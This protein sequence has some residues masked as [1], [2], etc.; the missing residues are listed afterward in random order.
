[1][2]GIS[3]IFLQESDLLPGLEFVRIMLPSLGLF[4]QQINPF[5]T[6]HFKCEKPQTYFDQISSCPWASFRSICMGMAKNGSHQIKGIFL[7]IKIFSPLCIS[8]NL[9]F[10]FANLFRSFPLCIPFTASFVALLIA[11]HLGCEP[12]Q[13]LT[14]LIC[15]EWQ[16]KSKIVGGFFLKMS[17]FCV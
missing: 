12:F 1:M 3:N 9:D 2:P 16:V 13:E 7:P 14:N 17:L 10:F 15:K 5:P 8:E 11:W 6:G 4:A